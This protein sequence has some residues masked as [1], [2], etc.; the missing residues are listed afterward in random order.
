MYQTLEHGTLVFDARE[1]RPFRQYWLVRIV[2]VGVERERL[3]KRRA[4]GRVETGH[5]ALEGAEQRVRARERALRE[6]HG[7]QLRILPSGRARDRPEARHVFVQQPVHLE[8]VRRL[9]DGQQMRAAA[10]R[11]AC[12]LAR[13][14]EEQNRL[15]TLELSEPAHCAVRRFVATLGCRPAHLDVTVL[16]DEPARP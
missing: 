9:A 2:D 8:S 1:R 12:V 7:D 6:H 13:P 14:A 11:E 4:D 16:V 10:S 5:A 3:L 15:V